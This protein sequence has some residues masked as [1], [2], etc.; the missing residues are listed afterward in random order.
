MVYDIIEKP[1]TFLSLML[2]TLFH[3]KNSVKREFIKYLMN[4]FS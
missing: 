3:F 2:K 1:L 4:N